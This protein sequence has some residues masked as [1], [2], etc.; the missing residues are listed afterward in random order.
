MEQLSDFDIRFYMYQVLEALEYAHQRG[1]MHRDVKPNNILIDPRNREVRLIDW[2]LAE[3]Y[4][5]HT[6][7]NANVASR[8][9]KG[10]E[11]LVSLKSYDYSLDLWS[12]GCVL[13]GLTFNMHPF[14]CGSDNYD[15]LRKIVKVLGCDD[16]FDYLNLYDISKPFIDEILARNYEKIPLVNFTCNKNYHKVSD[17]SINLLESLLKYDHMERL[18]AKESLNHPYFYPVVNYLKQNNN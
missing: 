11:L 9:F 10:P 18:T 8:Y 5:P 13:A 15:Q 17:L 2:G 12:F 6:E 1:I 14:F 7:Y 3:Y 4:F 16:F